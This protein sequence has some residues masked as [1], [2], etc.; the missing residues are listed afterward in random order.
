MK[1]LKKRGSLTIWLEEGFDQSNDLS[2]KAE[3]RDVDFAS[4]HP[5]HLNVK[6]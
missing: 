6:I 1:S 5:C 2:H 3:R 4:M